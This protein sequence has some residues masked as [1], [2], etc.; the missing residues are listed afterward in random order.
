MRKLIG[1]IL[2]PFLLLLSSTAQEKPGNWYIGIKSGA[3][4]G[5]STFSSFSGDKIRSGW[6]T[7]LSFGYRI[8]DLWSAELSA[9][10]GRVRMSSQD[11]CTAYYLGSDGQLYFAPVSG[12]DTY[13]YPSLYS[14]VKTQQYS[15]QIN[16]DLLRLVS[17]QRDRRWSLHLSPVLS[18]LVSK[19]TVRFKKGD[20]PAV[21]CSSQ[22]NVGLGGELSAGYRLN[23]QLT[24][25]L[26]SG[27]T[28][29]PGA[30]IDGMPKRLHRNNCIWESGLKLAWCPQ[31][32]KASRSIAVLPSKNS[33]DLPTLPVVKVK[34]QKPQETD[35]DSLAT[36]SVTAVP[37]VTPPVIIDSVVIKAKDSKPDLTFP[38][39]YFTFNSIRIES[40]QIKQTTEILSTLRKNPDIRIDIEGWCDRRG[41]K[42]V[43]IRIS[44]Q[45]AEALKKWLVDRGIPAER[46]TTRG[47]G[48]DYQ[49]QEAAKARRTTV[50]GG[51]L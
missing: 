46:I 2:L 10:I 38:T 50:K 24:A 5:V 33:S 23:R 44:L 14:E 3:T 6:N 17:P 11:C 49:E 1:T 47:N 7:G 26:Y 4:F 36:D 15:A 19:A 20:D 29:F 42:E 51:N 18:A 48:I 12:M 22:C 13:P 37:V 21:Q 30:R 27:V 8:S 43:N 32:K 35:K 39:I 40:S 41:S 16:F 25:S 9:A 34:A 31:R 28:Y 45:R